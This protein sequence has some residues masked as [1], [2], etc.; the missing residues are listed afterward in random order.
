MCGLRLAPL[1]STAPVKTVALQVARVDSRHAP[2]SARSPKKR[3]RIRTLKTI[4]TSR[5]FAYPPG[6]DR[7]SSPG[8]AVSSTP[9][10]L[11]ATQPLLGVTARGP[12]PTAAGQ[13]HCRPRCRPDPTMAVCPPVRN[14]VHDLKKN[15]ANNGNGS[16]PV[17]DVN[18]TFGCAPSHSAA[19]PR[20]PTAE[21]Q[22][23][24]RL[25]V[26]ATL[27]KA[28]SRPPQSSPKEHFVREARFWSVRNTANAERGETDWRLRLVSA[29]CLGGLASS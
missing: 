28:D 18:G 21:L 27:C 12:C 5:P 3:L 2:V 14:Q 11:R 19:G 9:Q 23:C 16:G 22:A 1:R 6:W 25:A 17:G 13:S 29:N 26:E 4:K 15:R 8:A 20:G 24:K 10:S 7:P